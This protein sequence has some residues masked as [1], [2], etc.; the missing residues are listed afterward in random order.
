[1]FERVRGISAKVERFVVGNRLSRR[2]IYTYLVATSAERWKYDDTC[3]FLFRFRSN[4]IIYVFFISPSYYPSTL[5]QIGAFI[6]IYTHT[7]WHELSPPARNKALETLSIYYILAGQ[8]F[9]CTVRF[10]KTRAADINRYNTTRRRRR[11][12]GFYYCDIMQTG[13]SESCCCTWHIYLLLLFV[14]RE[15]ESCRQRGGKYCYTRLFT[16]VKSGAARRAV[17]EALL[18]FILFGLWR[19]ARKYA[20]VQLL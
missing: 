17:V 11:R 15:R 9:L 5:V 4:T 19:G 3:R 14:E 6:R 20:S 12:G 18:M 7:L 1:M 13:Y 16:S 10:V 8:I 2:Y